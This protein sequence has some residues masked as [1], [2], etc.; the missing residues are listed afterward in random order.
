[1]DPRFPPVCISPEGT[2]G[3]GRSLLQFRSGADVHTNMI[4]QFRLSV[5]VISV[6]RYTAGRLNNRIQFHTPIDYTI[7]V[8]YSLYS[9]KPSIFCLGCADTS[10]QSSYIQPFLFPPSASYSTP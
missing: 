1:M 3:D 7:Y 6:D 2:C 10:L 9:Y 5:D 4:S 8:R